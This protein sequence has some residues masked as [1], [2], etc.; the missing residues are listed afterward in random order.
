MR[1]SSSLKSKAETP[2]TPGGISKSLLTPCRRL[3]LSRNWRKSIASPFNSPLAS[4]ET[5]QDN[6]ES[7]K[8][9][10]SLEVTPQ[11]T[12]NIC[13]EPDNVGTPIRKVELPRR[14]KSKTL[15]KSITKAE[16]DSS[17]PEPL[18]PNEDDESRPKD[19]VMENVKTEVQKVISTPVRLRSK[20]NE[21]TKEKV[22]NVNIECKV[23]IPASLSMCKKMSHKS[24]VSSTKIIENKPS[25][26]TETIEKADNIANKSKEK[27]LESPNKL[28]K[29]CI[30]VIQKKIFKNQLKDNKMAIDKIDEPKHTSQ[31]LFIDSDSDDVPLNCLNRTEDETIVVHDDDNFATNKPKL[32]ETSSDKSIKEKPA[33]TSKDKKAIVKVQ[34]H[35]PP[36]QCSIDDNDDF[37]EKKRTIVV[38]KSYDKVIKPLKAKSTGSITQKDIEDL[39]ARIETKKKMLLAKSMTETKELRELIKKWQKGCQDALMELMDLMKKKCPEENMEYSQILQTLKIPGNLVGYDSDNDCF[40]TPDEENIILSHI[41][42]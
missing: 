32:K 16:D 35:Y 12:E 5:K 26:K 27:K 8:R 41:K 38:R 31:A 6:V 14:K 19:I 42:E 18:T 39:K 29:E 36:S 3:G 17:E 13:D 28:T 22:D 9:K 2:K 30:V 15:L 23:S 24:I 34:I 10:E 20:G 37:V 21:I 4:T 11:R 1:N 33:K 25:Q 40:V 7:R